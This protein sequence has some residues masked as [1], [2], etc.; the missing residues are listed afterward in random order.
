[1]ENT[2]Y[3]PWNQANYNNGA[4][5]P[6]CGNN[7]CSLKFASR[8]IRNMFNSVYQNICAWQEAI[9]LMEDITGFLTELGQNWNKQFNDKCKRNV[10]NYNSLQRTIY[11]PVEFTHDS[12]KYYTEILPEEDRKRRNVREVPA[13]KVSAGVI[14]C[15]KYNFHEA[16]NEMEFYHLVRTKSKRRAFV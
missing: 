7:K 8:C 2:Y 12:E 16:K 3:C 10:D 5:S 1:M 9:K 4:Y 11:T 15:N 13:C 6:D 14:P